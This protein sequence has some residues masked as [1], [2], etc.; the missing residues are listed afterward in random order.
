MWLA[1]PRLQ[2]YMLACC[3]SS[4]VR[5]VSIP[6]PGKGVLLKAWWP[7]PMPALLRGVVTW[8]RCFPTLGLGCSTDIPSRHRSGM[9]KPNRAATLRVPGSL[10]QGL[11]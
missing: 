6:C 5:Q 10:G 8:T 9:W 11:G 4:S 7:G 3:L 1:W 2:G